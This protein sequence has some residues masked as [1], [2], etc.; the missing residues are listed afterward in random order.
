MN[1][2]LS[3]AAEQVRLYCDKLL[4]E[5]DE[6]QAAALRQAENDVSYREG[7]LR[8]M[9]EEVSI[10]YLMPS[11]LSLLFKSSMCRASGGERTARPRCVV[12]GDATNRDER[13]S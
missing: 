13:P 12:A 1:D 5:V 8:T 7:S 3:Q 4:E 11:H 9:R 6:A 10:V 2:F